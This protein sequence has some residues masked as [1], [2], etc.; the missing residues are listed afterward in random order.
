MSLHREFS[1]PERAAI[2]A[3]W[4]EV[5]VSWSSIA[6]VGTG[7]PWRQHVDAKLREG[8]PEACIF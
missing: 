4:G 5:S 3:A 2:V 6:M 8:E 1:E 7:Q